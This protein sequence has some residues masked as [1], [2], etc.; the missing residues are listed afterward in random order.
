MYDAV[1]AG[2]SISGLLCAREIARGGFTV[3]VLEEGF[4]VG[5]PEHC[6]GLVSGAGLG[7]L[8][9]V[10]TQRT[11][12]R[13]VSTAEIFAPNGKS[14]TVDAKRQ[15]V[16]ELSRRELDKQA[17]LQ[18]QK[19]GAE[20]RVNTQVQQIGQGSV[21]TR[22]GTIRCRMAVD[23]RGVAPLIR[24]DREGALASAQYEVCADWMP[25][26]RIQV[27]IDQERYPG[28]FAWIIPSGG[29]GA[30][31]AK[32]G[33]AGRGINAAAALDG[34]LRGRGD[35]NFSVTRKIF[36]PVWVKGPIKDFVDGGIVTVGDAAGQ[37]KPTTA[38]GIYSAGMGGVMAGEAISRFLGSGD[39]NDLKEYQRR[40]RRRFGREFERQLLAR[41]ML[42]GLDN[43]ACNRMLGSVTPEIT[44]GMAGGDDFDFHTGSIIRILGLKRSL[45]AAQALAGSEIKRLFG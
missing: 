14:V 41:R 38:G 20:I 1:V 17:A 3:L 15:G 45:R 44:A 16:I 36:A 18:A 39:R 31:S 4:E 42:E 27:F 34:F 35:G 6:S 29:G 13:A 24:R 40:W 37:T 33:V 7:E 26:D 19:N 2:G 10:P 28:F 9:I 22:D 32:A 5:T 21:R 25:A 8:G 30:G 12:G 43:E 11:F 23:A